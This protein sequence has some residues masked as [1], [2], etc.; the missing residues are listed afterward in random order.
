MKHWFYENEINKNFFAFFENLIC[1]KG[2][3]GFD[4]QRNL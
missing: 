4:R 3:H 1:F 2:S